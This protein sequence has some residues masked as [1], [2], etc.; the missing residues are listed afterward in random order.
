SL[1]IGL[2]IGSS[3]I[4]ASLINT[5]TGNLVTSASSP[6]QEMKIDSPKKGWAEQHPETWWQHVKISIKKLLDVLSGDY[7]IDGIGISYQM[8]GRSEERRVGKECRS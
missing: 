3:S 6:E 8:H 2:D 7:E 5:S 1:L 4:K